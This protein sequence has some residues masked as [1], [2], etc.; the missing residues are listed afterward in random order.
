MIGAGTCC[1]ARTLVC[2]NNEQVACGLKLV[3]EI[4]C[5]TS[6]LQTQCG[7]YENNDNKIVK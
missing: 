7:K 1:T 6:C 3:E 2:R 4:V 5:W